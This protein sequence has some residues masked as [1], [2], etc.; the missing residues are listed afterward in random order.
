MPV[1]LRWRSLYDP[2]TRGDVNLSLERIHFGYG[3]TGQRWSCRGNRSSQSRCSWR[4]RCRRNATWRLSGD[5]TPDVHKCQGWDDFR[6]APGTCSILRSSAQAVFIR[7]TR[8][9]RVDKLSPKILHPINLLDES[10][11]SGWAGTLRDH[12]TKPI[13]CERSSDSLDGR[14]CGPW[15]DATASGA[16]CHWIDT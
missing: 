10:G 1:A 14:T 9:G 13:S 7:L 8:E 16:A 15:L 4:S 3:P 2:A 11:P 5:S 6:I 12:I